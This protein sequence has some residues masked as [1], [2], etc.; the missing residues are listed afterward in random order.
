MK[1]SK[2]AFIVGSIRFAKNMS[3]IL[4][5]KSQKIS[6]RP[7]SSGNVKCPK[8]DGSEQLKGMERLNYLVDEMVIRLGE[9]IEKG[10]MPKVN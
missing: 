7:S 5:R 2:I 4:E 6:E 3:T 1:N 10:E 9:A 8:P